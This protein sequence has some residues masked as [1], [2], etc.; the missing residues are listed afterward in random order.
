M[1]KDTHTPLVPC[2]LSL[3]NASP[4]FSFPLSLSFFFFYVKQ[5]ETHAQR[6]KNPPSAH[7]EI[8][9]RWGGVITVLYLTYSSRI[10]EVAALYCPI[11]P[12]TTVRSSSSSSS[13]THGYNTTHPT[14]NPSDPTLPNRTLLPGEDRFQHSL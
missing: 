11:Q 12:N 2:L 8:T 6:G 9:K 4:P 10:T 14:S 7:R 13:S 5:K 1:L 3:A